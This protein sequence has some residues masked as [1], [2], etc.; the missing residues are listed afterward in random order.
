MEKKITPGEWYSQSYS[1]CDSG[2]YG[3]D[4][5]DIALVRENSPHFK[6]NIQAIEA[7][8]NLIEACKA[9]LNMPDIP[10]EI[11]SKI[12]SALQKARCEI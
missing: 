1:P 3:Q 2:V 11:Y 4:G 12:M 5:K 7:V 9:T 8:P 6:A 10:I